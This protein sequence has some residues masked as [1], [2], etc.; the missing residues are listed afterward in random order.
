MSVPFD[1]AVADLA[2][3]NT[4]AVFLQAIA[5]ERPDQWDAVLAHPNVYPDL[6]QW[7][8]LSRAA[9]AATPPP[10]VARVEQVERAAP[11]VTR[12][13][14]SAP[15]ATPRAVPVV[16]PTVE[17]EPEPGSLGDELF[18]GFDAGPEPTEVMAPV[19]GG[20]ETTQVLP[21]TGP[22][23]LQWMEPIAAYTP[24][25]TAAPR[26]AVAPQAPTPKTHR[27]RWVFLG[28]GIGLVVG[29]G[30]A[31]CL[32]VWVLPGMFGPLL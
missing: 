18:G 31:I 14:E 6:V 4:P 30:V 3:P 15:V 19:R 13:V 2:D 25:E 10:D 5:A 29:L 16:T 24:L 23:H 20:P 9:A 22:D 28:V 8:E 32:V 27:V 21:L 7:I 26:P 17:P 1:R 12:V 11:A